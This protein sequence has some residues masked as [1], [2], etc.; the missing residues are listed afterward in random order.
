MVQ[1][2][3]CTFTYKTVKAYKAFED[4]I[5]EKLNSKYNTIRKSINK[6]INEGYLIDKQYLDFWKIYTDY[7]IIKNQIFCSDYKSSKKIIKEHR[8]KNKLKN[9]QPDASQITFFSPSNFYKNIKFN[10]GQYVLIDKN[11]WQLICSDELIEEEGGVKYYIEKGKIIFTFGQLG[12]IEIYTNDNIINGTK[13]ILNKSRNDD[14]SE[15]FG[16]KISNKQKNIDDYYDEE[17]EE[18]GDSSELKKLILLYAYEQELK[19]KINDL[20]YKDNNF[21][22]YYLISKDWI[23]EYK[24]YYHYNE[25]SKMINNRNDLKNILNKGYNWAKK[26]IDY[27]LSKISNKKPKEKFPK[28]LKEQNT[29]FS[30]G[31][32]INVDDNN[33]NVTYWKDF[34]I[35]NEELKNLFSK[36]DENGYYFKGASSAKIL[37]NE[38]KIILDLSNDE[39]NK[40]IYAFEIG[41]IGN[42]DMIFYEE[43]IFQ[44]DDEKYKNNHFKIFKD[45]IYTFQRDKLDFDINLKCNLLSDDDD[46]YGCAIK[47]PHNY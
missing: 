38:G 34:E 5:Q 6:E 7:N 31:N 28:E 35:V 12:N 44:Y 25:L 18:E 2:C 20:R 45:D 14:E 4:Y 43:Y 40:E 21:K 22:L 29:F 39:N 36:S 24:K 13:K 16:N 32:E 41:V 19:N 23:Q 30:D 10:G 46:I 15:D 9:Y 42:K 33:S 26:N 1:E 27:A 47:L 17:N 11:F 3:E 37:I 8:K